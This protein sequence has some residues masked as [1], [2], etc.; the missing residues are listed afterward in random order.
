MT[1]DNMA[2]KLKRQVYAK[3]F[4]GYLIL[5]AIAVVFI[6]FGYGGQGGM[7]MGGIGTI[8]QVNN[9]FISVSDFR[10]EENRIQEYYSS[11]FGGSFDL[12][13]QKGLLQQQAMENLIRSELVSQA[14]QKAG[15]LATDAEVREIIVKDIPVFQEKG[16]FIRDRYMGYLE[17]TKSSPADFESRL[18]KDIVGVRSR[19]LFEITAY[20]MSFEI[21]KLKDLRSR[22]LNIGF[23]KLDVEQIAL[24]TQMSEQAAKEKL[25][26][27]AWAKKA[28][29][30]FKAHQSEWNKEESVQAQHILATFKAGDSASEAA[31]LEKIKKAQARLVKEDFGTVAAQMSDDPGSK[32]KKGMLEPFSKGRMVK[33][34]EDAAFALK[35]GELSQP[36]KS[37]FGYHLIKVLSHQQA[38]VAQFGDVQVKVAQKLLAREQAESIIKSIEEAIAKGEVAQVNSLLA[39]AKQNWDE[40][41][42]FDLSSDAIPKIPAGP[43]V[44]AAFELNAKKPFLARIVRDSGAKY[45]LKLNGAKTEQVTEDAKSSDTLRRQRADAMHASWINE[46]RQKSKITTSSEVFNQ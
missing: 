27:A 14:A 44:E 8:A 40:T 11:L 35:S 34:F 30:H 28:E 43:V 42:F 29:D 3:K 17:A 25:A 7:G 23:V 12:S 45:I 21:D 33:E 46:F 20:P 41:G 24:G 36:V 22:K 4:T 15:L 16:Q 26:D 32:A 13:S 18:R 37:A 19:H 1:T 9:T 31:A 5:G 10:N 6:F 39:Q 2:H 38:V